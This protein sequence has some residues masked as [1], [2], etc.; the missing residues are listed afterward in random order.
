[1]TVCID[2]NATQYHVS[3]TYTESCNVPVFGHF[4]QTKSSGWS[5]HYAAGS[6]ATP[7]TAMF[8]FIPRRLNQYQSFPTQHANNIGNQGSVVQELSEG[9]HY[10]RESVIKKEFMLHLPHHEHKDTNT[11]HK[12]E[13]GF[14]VLQDI[15][16]HVT[17]P[18]LA[19]YA[20]SFTHNAESRDHVH[21]SLW[22][23]NIVSRILKS[24]R[25]HARDVATLV[26]LQEP[27][28][29][30][31]LMAYLGQKSGQDCEYRTL[32]EAID[33]ATSQQHISISIPVAPV[34]LRPEQAI[35]VEATT[36]SLHECVYSQT[37]RIS[38]TSVTEV[39]RT[40]PQ[41]AY[42]TLG[43]QTNQ[44]AYQPLGTGD[45][46]VNIS[47]TAAYVPNSI[48]YSQQ[49]QQQAQQRV[50]FMSP[51]FYAEPRQ[52]MAVLEN[53]S[54][55]NKDLRSVHV[56]IPPHVC[57]QH[58]VIGVT[59]DITTR[60]D[61]WTDRY[62]SNIV[63]RRD[64]GGI[65]ATWRVLGQPPVVA[66]RDCGCAHTAAVYYTNHTPNDQSVLYL[67]H[68]SGGIKSCVASVRLASS[69]GD[70]KS[71]H[72]LEIRRQDEDEGLK[73][74]QVAVSLSSDPHNG[75][76]SQI[77]LCV[78]IDDAVRV[79]RPHVVHYTQANGAQYVE[80]VGSNKRYTARNMYIDVLVIG[81]RRD[82]QY[83]DFETIHPSLV[84]PAQGP[85]N[86]FD[87]KHF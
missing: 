52:N 65:N 45:V 1:M 28:L 48:V 39:T 58:L 83:L 6:F 85:T 61:S 36:A 87:I 59:D 47:I 68:T 67:N 56:P 21:Y 40:R 60:Y 63:F 35:V 27:N 26:D 31:M 41:V 66:I 33:R 2:E 24:L 54:Q 23:S 32:E 11:D 34:F 18:P 75:V 49:Q 81:F 17:L 37:S 70:Q 42:P 19:Q 53:T 8:S 79:L 69:F 38:N 46:G 73:W 84:Q 78:E 30:R 43:R 16:V 4:E 13:H 20:P 50:Q 29:Y 80:D 14:M 77:D 9:I 71:Q 22:A 44:I 57:A 62:V 55:T 86:V 51:V 82:V 76:Q 10:D 3:N 15:T 12:N 25:I 74:G 7:T 72:T 5:R 64:M